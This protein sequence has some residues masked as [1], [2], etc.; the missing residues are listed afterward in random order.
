MVFLLED[1]RDEMKL[2][3]NITKV[4]S[5]AKSNFSDD[6]H[7]VQLTFCFLVLLITCFAQFTL[8]LPSLRK[9]THSKVTSH[10]RVGQR[11]PR[12][13]LIDTIRLQQS[14]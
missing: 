10:G 13:A 8:I 5:E 2:N 3:A 6:E 11:G 12:Y 7:E 1:I 4:L 14:G 9:L